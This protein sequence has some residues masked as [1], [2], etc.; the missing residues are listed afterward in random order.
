M[1]LI[2]L[3]NS[4]ILLA[5]FY[6]ELTYQ[7]QSRAGQAGLTRLI[8]S[9]DNAS[10]SADNRLI[11][12]KMLLDQPL[13]EGPVSRQYNILNQGIWRWPNGG[14][15]DKAGNTV[16]I[17]HRFTYTNPRGVFYFLNK[18]RVGHK[19]RY[20]VSQTKVVPPTDTSIEAPANDSRLTL[21]TCTP[22]WLPKDRLAVIARRETN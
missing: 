17:G 7:R 11:I 5:P 13:L 9:P 21:F 3:V 8:Q 14:A 2:I 22:L 18:L 12:P 15:P 6:P 19:Y 10:G 20:K 16:L 1:G 4:Y